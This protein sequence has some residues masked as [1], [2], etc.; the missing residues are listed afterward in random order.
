MKD[1]RTGAEVRKAVLDATCRLGR[2]IWKK[3]TGCLCVPRS[4]IAL[5]DR[6]CHDGDHAINPPGA[7]GITRSADLCN[8]ATVIH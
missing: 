3:S 2:K 4:S 8:K 6:E 7:W 1:R 5:R